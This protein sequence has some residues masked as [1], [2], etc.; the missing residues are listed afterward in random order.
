ME[1]EIIKKKIELLGLKKSHVAKQI[2]CR[3]D[4]LSHFLGD[5]RKLRPEVYT[6][7]I[8]YLS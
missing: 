8:T 5:R 7:L 1:L 2:G 6:R 3:S 4:E